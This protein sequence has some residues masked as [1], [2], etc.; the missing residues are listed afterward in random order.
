MPEAPTTRDDP[1]CEQVERARML[2]LTLE[3]VASEYPEHFHMATWVQSQDQD[4]DDDAS[5][6]VDFTAHVAGQHPADCGTVGCA[7]G[8][9]PYATG[10]PATPFMMGTGR[11]PHWMAPLTNWPGYA[12]Q[13]L[14]ITDEGREGEDGEG[15]PPDWFAYIFLTHTDEDGE[16]GATNAAA[17]LWEWIDAHQD[18]CRE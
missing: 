11:R 14:G 16:E 1:T 8:W 10:M 18:T 6:G 7:L 2:A 17:R 12:R 15:Q 3:K 5:S 9:A 13:V 4:Q